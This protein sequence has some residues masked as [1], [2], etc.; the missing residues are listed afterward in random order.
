ME[1]AKEGE[2]AFALSSD[3]QSDESEKRASDAHSRSDKI[4][5]IIMAL[6]SGSLYGV[7]IA[8]V[9][10]IQ[11]N[12]ASFDGAPI[13][14]LP[15]VFSHYFG[16]F[17]T[18][19]LGFVVYA[20]IRKNKPAINPNIAVPALIA[21]TLWGVAQ[22]LLIMA[23]SHLSVAISYPI[24]SMLPGCIAA[25]W[26]VFYFHEI[27]GSKNLTLLLAAIMVTLCGAMCIGFSK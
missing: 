22:T 18:C 27:E 12:A 7:N 8:P 13:D 17:I 2:I 20:L 5:G 14:G 9:V 15:Y 21:G 23:T 25:I 11:D 24:G 19:T 16:A 26:S 1:K 6:I 3:S 10:Y 4:I